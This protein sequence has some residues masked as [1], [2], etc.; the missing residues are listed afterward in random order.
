MRTQTNLFEIFLRRLFRCF[1]RVFVRSSQFVKLLESFYV[2]T[3]NVI[4]VEFSC[5]HYNWVFILI[6]TLMFS[7]L[8]N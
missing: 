5:K 3:S 4:N 7:L 8:I 2:S 6:F 1:F